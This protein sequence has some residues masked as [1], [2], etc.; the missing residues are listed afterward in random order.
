[1]SEAADQLE[2]LD[3]CCVVSEGVA[4]VL[5]LGLAAV[6]SFQAPALVSGLCW[7][8]VSLGWLPDGVGVVVVSVVT[9]LVSCPMVLVSLGVGVCPMVVSVV[10]AVVSV[11]VTAVVSPWFGAAPTSSS[12]RLWQAASDAAAASIKKYLI[13]TLLGPRT[14]PA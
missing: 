6:L 12:E 3:Y 14:L 9:V 1:L 2:S 10:T 11:A 8:N 13:S 7:D 4:A 5:S